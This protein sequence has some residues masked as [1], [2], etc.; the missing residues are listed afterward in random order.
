MPFVI[1]ITGDTSRYLIFESEGKAI[2]A[3]KSKNWKDEEIQF[4]VPY[5]SQLTHIAV[6][7]ILVTE[8]SG[9]TPLELSFELHKPLLEAFTQHLEHV[10]NRRYISC[11]I[12]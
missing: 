11:P 4:Q 1:N 9:L 6:S 8:Q 5:Q 2:Q 10:V 7:K 12:T 3:H